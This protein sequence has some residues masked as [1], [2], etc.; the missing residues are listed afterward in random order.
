MSVDL[1]LGIIIWLLIAG[2][3][4]L[5]AQKLVAMAPIDA[6][7]KQII[8]VVL[9]IVVAMI[10]LFKVIIPLLQAVAHIS[11]SVH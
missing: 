1:V 3:M 8:D 4:Y 7:F 10:V 9:W 11:I 5:A 6:W 2:F